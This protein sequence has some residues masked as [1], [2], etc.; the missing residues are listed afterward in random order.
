M[1]GLAPVIST[2]PRSL[3]SDRRE[4]SPCDA[5]RAPG[6]PAVGPRSMTEPRT[7][8]YVPAAHDQSPHSTA[9]IAAGQR[10]VIKGTFAMSAA[11]RITWPAQHAAARAEFLCITVLHGDCP[12][13]PHIG[14]HLGGEADR[15]SRRRG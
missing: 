7:P 15:G 4:A 2:A 6:E 1:P 14:R 9:R 13:L 12:L 8:R 11:R 10:A 5:P 3:C